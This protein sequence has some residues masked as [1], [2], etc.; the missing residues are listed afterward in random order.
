MNSAT[1]LSENEA[2]PP[3]LKI[4][5]QSALSDVVSENQRAQTFDPFL[6]LNILPS[7]LLKA[8][9]IDLCSEI[10]CEYV[11]E[12]V[13]VSLV[14]DQSKYVSVSVYATLLFKVVLLLSC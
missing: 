1:C 14:G 7:Q 12:L 8:A 9:H 10:I 5:L 2:Q 11:F 6:K 3:E 13:Y 4:N